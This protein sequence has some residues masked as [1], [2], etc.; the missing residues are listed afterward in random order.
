MDRQRI[1]E[2]VADGSRT[3]CQKTGTRSR[4]CAGLAARPEE[5]SQLAR[6]LCEALAKQRASP[7]ARSGTQLLRPAAAAAPRTSA[8]RAGP[9]GPPLPQEPRKGEGKG[10]PPPARNPSPRPAVRSEGAAGGERRGAPAGQGRTAGLG[11]GEGGTRRGGR[12]AGGAP[13]S[14]PAAGPP[15]LAA[16]RRRAPPAGAARGGGG[17]GGGGGRAPGCAALLVWSGAW[18]RQERRRRGGERQPEPAGRRQPRPPLSPPSPPPALLPRGFLCAQ[19]RGGPDPWS[20]ATRRARPGEL[21]GAGAGGERCLRW[22]E[23]G[24]GGRE[25]ARPGAAVCGDG[26]CRPRA[27]GAWGG[28][29]GGGGAP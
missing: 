28:G 29:S 27:A 21:G 25:G 23:R 4:L 10:S 22:R 19:G 17:G 20:W 15:P 24:E 7:R 6:A 8:R 11:G 18:Q 14:G 5:K 3:R 26:G 1:H 12:G 13:R 16:A 9:P 2:D